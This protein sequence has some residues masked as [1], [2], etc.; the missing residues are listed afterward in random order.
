M[1]EVVAEG[2]QEEIVETIKRMLADG[3]FKDLESRARW[4]EYHVLHSVD[5][6]PKCFEQ[7]LS[8]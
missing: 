4:D 3:Y 5:R 8:K 2:N 6:L 7:L 1:G